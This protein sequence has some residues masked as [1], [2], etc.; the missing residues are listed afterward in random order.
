MQYLQDIQHYEDRY[1]IWTIEQ[2]LRQIEMLRKVSK[3]MQGAKELKHLSLEEKNNQLGMIGG[4]II[5]NIKICRYKKREETLKE[6]IDKDRQKQ[7]RQD[8]TPAP[9][10]VKCD[11]CKGKMHSEFHHLSSS[12]G[13]D[14]DRVL[15]LFRCKNCKDGKGVFENGEI[16]EREPDI[17]EKCGG[18]LDHTFKK[19]KRYDTWT[20]FCTKCDYKKVDKTDIAKEKQERIDEKKRKKELLEKYRDRFCFK[21]EEAEELIQALEELKFANQ[22]YEYE[23][24]K[25]ESPEYEQT[26]NL[27]KLSA[28]ELEELL[29]QNLKKHK[30]DRLNMKV[31]E[32]GQ[33]VEVSFSTQDFDKSRNE[34]ESIQELKDLLA[35]TLETTNWRP[36][37]T[38]SNR[39]GF[40]MATLRGYERDEDILKSLM[41]SDPKPKKIELDPELEKKY[42]HSNAVSLAKMSAEFEGKKRLRMK[43]YKTEPEGFVLE[44]HGNNYYTCNLCHRSIKGNET[45][46]IPEAQ[47][48]FD[49][50][51]NLKKGVF[52]V[53][54]FDNDKLWF[55]T[56]DVEK[57]FGMHNATVRK[58]IRK[59]DLVGRALKDEEGKEYYKIFIAEDNLNFFKTHPRKGERKQRWHYVDKD[60]EVVWL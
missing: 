12:S 57:E 27:Q 29:N 58:H 22:V 3:E 39:L 54:I 49:C 38:V 20:E 59:G 42:G 35:D 18:E 47:L 21:K 9:K 17:C 11:K 50:N 51:R 24:Q 7:D 1:D 40:L 44:T 5:M 15:F 14:D 19:T 52:P 8:N 6:W 48:C 30:F 4:R 34:K 37:G 26:H 2:C 55:R 46:W 36:N 56:W 16:W 43:R 60:G 31:P 33:Y 41:K 32:F 23:L 53:D 25:Y 10:N 45:W 28:V 13:G